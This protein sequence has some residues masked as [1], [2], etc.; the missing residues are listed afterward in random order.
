MNRIWLAVAIAGFS[1]PAAAATLEAP[2]DLAAKGRMQCFSPDPVKKTCKSMAGYRIGRNGNIEDIATVVVSG[3]PLVIMESISPVEITDGKVCGRVRE[4]DF[5][6][7]NFSTDGMPAD[8]KQTQ[9]LA[10]AAVLA[11]KQLLGRF[12]CTAY[13]SDGDSVK[14][15]STVDGTPRPDMEQAVIWVS[16]DDGYRIAAPAQ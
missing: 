15:K 4:Q 5:A 1:L 10:H 8:M 9:T 13:V 2:L 12:I 16:L 11:A 3:S 7:A 6:N 14:A